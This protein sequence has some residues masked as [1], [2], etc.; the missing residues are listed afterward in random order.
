MQLT[1]LRTLLITSIG[2]GLLSACGSSNPT[3]TTTVSPMATSSPESPSA[4]APSPTAQA[5]TTAAKPGS[6]GGQGGQII[7]SGPYHLEL[8]TIEEADGTHIDFF[9]QQGDAHEPIPNANVTAQVQLPNGSQ[10]SLAM[11]YD[12][13]GKHYYA[14]LPGT[15]PGE[16]KVAILSDIQGEKVNARYTFKR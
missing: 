11:Q 16:Y 12:V 6:H 14:V 13:E 7:E 8:L 10:T 2:I 9:L 15:M 4:T 1:N 5:T 3:P